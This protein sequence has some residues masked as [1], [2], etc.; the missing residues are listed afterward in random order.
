MSSSIP[1]VMVS[2]TCYDLRDLRASLATFIEQAGYSPLLSELASFPID[3]DESTVENCRRRVESNADV[4]ILVI[5]GRYGHADSASAKSVT[6]LEY[7]TARAKGIPIYAFVRNDILSV[8]PVWKENPTAR[9]SSVV[10]DLRVFEFIEQVR[11]IDSVWM[12]GFDTPQDIIPT[13]KAQFA[14]LMKEALTWRLRAR[15]LAPASLQGLHGLPLR[16]VLEKPDFWEY[17]LFFALMSQELDLRESLTKE[18]ELGLAIGEPERVSDHDLPR[19]FGTRMTELTKLV[20]ALKLLCGRALQKAMGPPGT[21]GEAQDI[22]FVA[23]R[24]VEVYERLILWSRRVRL[25][26]SD[27]AELSE[28][29]EDVARL[30][31]KVV[32]NMRCFAKAGPQELAEQISQVER[33]GREPAFEFSLVLELSDNHEAVAQR[34]VQVITRIFRS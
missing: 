27:D 17:R 1:T 4:L 13:L 31:D 12:R 10:D 5:G 21:P 23:Q 7:L 22:R 6:N 32:N 18:H 19:W 33:G 9:F 25:L 16:L 34:M 24:I 20:D 3:P 28:V 29:I 30:T 8:L 2:S 11:S 26:V 14:H 15:S